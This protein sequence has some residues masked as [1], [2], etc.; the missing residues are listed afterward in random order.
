M[1]GQQWIPAVEGVN[2]VGKLCW[3]NLTEPPLDFLGPIHATYSPSVPTSYLR[4]RM[5]P[6]PE[7]NHSPFGMYFP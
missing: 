2:Y 3:I 6:P 4:A 7:A 1:E 5:V